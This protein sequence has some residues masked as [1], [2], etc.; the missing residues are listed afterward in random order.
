MRRLLLA[1]L[2]LTLLPACGGEEG[3]ADEDASPGGGGTVV[4][5]SLGEFAIE[6]STIEADAG[7]YTF[8]VT[9]DGGAVH[10]LEIEGP[11][12]EVET[13]ELA[14]GESADLTLDLEDGEYEMYCPVG[15][16]R[17]RGMEGTI[18]V[19]GGGGGGTTTDDDED[20]DEDEDSGYRY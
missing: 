2:A 3:G 9:N 11:S 17:D 16:H 12:G 19:G 8:H 14:S 15:D 18:V 20:E 5:V 10:A 13:A 6:P 1:A 4:E 7:S